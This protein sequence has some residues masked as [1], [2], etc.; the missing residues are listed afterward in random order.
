MLL[1]QVPLYCNFF[2]LIILQGNLHETL[3]DR[4]EKIKSDRMC[5]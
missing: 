4:R 1:L 3:L 5:K 2:L